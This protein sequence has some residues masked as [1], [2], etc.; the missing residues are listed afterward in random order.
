MISLSFLGAAQT[1]TGSKYLL[2]VD[3]DLILVDCGAFQGLKELRLLNWDSPPFNAHALKWMVLTH[4]HIDHIG[5]VPRLWK[6]GFR[7]TIFCSAPTARLAEIL[8]LDA[9]QLHE[10]DARYLNKTA[11]T[12]HKPALPLFTTD[13]AA[14]SLKLFHP[15][16]TNSTV[17]IAPSINLELR[18]VGHIL[19]ACTVHLTLGRGQGKRRILFS[20]D[21][22]RYS[23]PLLPDPEPPV[24]ADYLVLESTYGDRLHSGESP[25]E[26]LKQLVN[27]IVESK[28]ILIIP[29]FAVG[30]TQLLVHMFCLLATRGDIPD[31]PVHV[32]S[33]MAIDAAEIQA[34]FPELRREGDTSEEEVCG[35]RAHLVKYHRTRDSSQSLNTLTG[36]AIIISSSGMLSGGRVLH[37]LIHHGG[38]PENIVAMA[39]Y[40]AAGTRGRDLLEGKKTIKFHGFTHTIAAEVTAISGLSG[41]ADFSEILRWLRPLSQVPE[42]TFI[43]HG[44]PGPA[45]AMAGHVKEGLGHNPIV[46]E[47]GDIHEL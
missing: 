35:K 27:Q 18:P 36:P 26:S 46:P 31:I 24:E 28:G 21:I 16:R 41:H 33:P 5:L 47:L 10:E 20:G 17:E 8:L 43:T 29:A 11:A 38:K 37:H 22:G 19:G 2:R 30:R 44:E 7:G 12:R 14:A 25:F 23:L 40:Q 32:D 6:Y 1:V 13:E 39:G 3:H 45:S 42:I 9:A 15:V 34:D 4:A